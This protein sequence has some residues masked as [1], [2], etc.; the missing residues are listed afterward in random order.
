[1]TRYRTLTDS[2]TLEL[3]TWPGPFRSVASGCKSYEIRKNDRD[4]RENDCLV[5]REWDPRYERYTG[6]A[7]VCR[8]THITYGGSFGLPDGLCVMALGSLSVSIEKSWA[9]QEP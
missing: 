4:Y 6:S 2:K 7:I 3:K 9:G 5:L 8:V 1:M